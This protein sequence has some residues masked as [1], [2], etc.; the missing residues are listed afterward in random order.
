MKISNSFTQGK[1]NKDLDERLI[2]KGQYRDAL[3]IEVNASEGAGI[4]AVE[5]VKG[6]T[7]IGTYPYPSNEN[8]LSVIGSIA[9]QSTNDIFFLVTGSINDYVLQYNSENNQITTLLQ[10]T[11]GRVLKFNSLNLITGI[12]IIDNLLFWTDDLNPPRR[13]DVSNSYQTDAFTEDDISVIVKPPLY[14]PKIFLTD[15]TESG[16]LSGK[17]NNI[18]DK[19]IQFSYRYKYEN[20]E[21]SAMSP[22]SA[23]AFFPKAFSYNYADAEFTSMVNNFNEVDVSFLTGESQV[24]EVQVLFRD[25]LD[26]SV[27]VIERF[28]KSNKGWGDNAEKTITFSNNKIFSLLP[29]DEVTRLFDNVP[30]QAKS[31][32]IIGSRLIYGNYTQF[33]NIDTILDYQLEHNP[34][35][36]STNP[37]RT[38]KSN[39]DYEVGV[40]Y[41][42][43]YGRMSTVLTSENNAVHIPIGSSKRSNSLRITLNNQAPTFATN[44]RLFIKQNKGV[45]YNIFPLYYYIDGVY[46]WFRISQSDVDKVK[47]GDYITVK[48][49]NDTA[50]DTLEKMKVIE[51]SVQERDYLGNNELPGLYFKVRVDNTSLF[52]GSNIREFFTDTVGYYYAVKAPTSDVDRYAGNIDVPVYYGSRT[53]SYSKLTI[54]PIGGLDLYEPNGPVDMPVGRYKILMKSFDTFQVLKFNK[55]YDIHLK[56]DDSSGAPLSF[57]DSFSGG[58]RYIMPSDKIVQII[59]NSTSSSNMTVAKFKFEHNSGY[60]N[61]DYW[62]INILPSEGV[63]FSGN[64]TAVSLQSKAIFPGNSWSPTTGG[65]QVSYPQPGGVFTLDRPVES[66]AIIRLRLKEE[67]EEGT[68]SFQEWQEWVS[69]R[70]YGNIQEW[71]WESGAY[72]TFKQFDLEGK[73]IGV[74]NVYFRRGYNRRTEETE[75]HG[76]SIGQKD[77]QVNF[78]SQTNT[79]IADD[80]VSSTLS[81]RPVY[82][83][84][85]ASREIQYDIDGIDI[86]D[87]VLMY[88]EAEITMQTGLNVFETEGKENLEDVFYEVPRT[89]NIENRKHQVLWK[90]TDFTSAPESTGFF[91]KTN[92][93]QASPGSTPTDTE[94]PAPFV[95]GET[96]YVDSDNNTN[97]P[98]GEYTIL[99]IRDPYNIILDLSFPGSGPVTGGGV[100]YT[101]FDQDQTSTKPLKITLNPMDAVNTEF[102]AYSFGNGVESMVVRGDWNGRHLK[103]SPRASSTYEDYAQERVEEALTY[104]GVYRENTGINN[105]N[106]FNLSLANFKYLDKAFGSIQK[107]KSRDTDL[108]VFQENKVSKILYGKN[109]L[110]DAVGGGTVASIPE[111]LGTQVSFAGEYGISKNPESF[112]QWGNNMYFA[113]EYRGAVCR[114][115]NNGIFEI[116]SFGMADWFKDLFRDQP[117]KRKMGGIDPFKGRYVIATRT[118]GLPIEFEIGFEE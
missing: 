47:E 65:D 108:V 5:N 78:I 96:I 36:I 83:F 44:Y 89:Y 49:N 16:N 69:P 61:G 50:V 41:L 54:L 90:Y 115:S 85:G 95:A 32:D 59:D 80:E 88:T 68:G 56:V 87:D 23:T 58:R 118:L 93:G 21:Y 6:N 30:L 70:R 60:S 46:R 33:F 100:S 109:L 31:Q 38:F 77:Y 106:E 51:V 105:F 11:K 67:V 92:L 12:N 101:S 55:G 25:T 20:N 27:F 37:K 117:G 39:R 82:M 97:F 71:F 62:I 52:D 84:I 110:S 48:V 73:N 57:T 26:N 28:N 35:Y 53:D 42:D 99:S 116:S 91:G 13:L 34:T 103:Y 14:P 45:F 72:R 79:L 107:I 112:A 8:N 22:F 24:K 94:F 2:P 111:V 17:E 75:Q 7:L 102:N 98:S 4:G 1:M 81:R 43:Q 104:S 63:N 66:G 3:N 114:L 18:E 29:P 15:T 113:D 64:S 9:N 19:F 40:A 10:D 74:D 86:I 76:G